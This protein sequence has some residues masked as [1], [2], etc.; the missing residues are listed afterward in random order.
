[1][2]VDAM[3]R[4]GKGKGGKSKGSKDK[5][6]GSSKGKDTEKEKVVRFDGYCEH[7]G[8][9]GHRQKDCWSRHRK[10]VNS[11][12]TDTAEPQDVDHPSEQTPV[13][14][15]ALTCF[16]PPGLHWSEGWIMTL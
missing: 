8:K 5:E 13:P 10:P 15:A 9:W 4:K 6:K 1:M 12:E 7:C 11:V 2:D 3:T 16:S 14:A